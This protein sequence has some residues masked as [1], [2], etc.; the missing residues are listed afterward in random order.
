VIKLK[1]KIGTN[2]L[3]RYWRYEDA[4]KVMHGLIM[5]AKTQEIVDHP[6]RYCAQ[7]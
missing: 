3:E 2:T 7:D 5:R 6:E 1:E 4:Q